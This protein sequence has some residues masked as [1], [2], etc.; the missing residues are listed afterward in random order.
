MTETN[1]KETYK[2]ITIARLNGA[3]RRFKLRV[4]Y[5]KGQKEFKFVDIETNAQVGD[6]LILERLHS[7]NINEWRAAARAAREGTGTGTTSV[8]AAQIREFVE[9]LDETTAV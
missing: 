3:L 8:A 5:T 4:E 2:Y 9:S 6:T 1:T 7:L